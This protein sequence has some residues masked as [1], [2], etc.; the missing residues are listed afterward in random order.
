M[1]SLPLCPHL[2]VVK[3]YNQL[4]WKH[5]I[6]KREPTQEVQLVML[7]VLCVV[8][9]LA[10]EYTSTGG[11]ERSSVSMVRYQS[12]LARQLLPKR[13]RRGHTFTLRLW[14]CKLNGRG[15]AK[16]GAKDFWN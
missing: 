14:Q 5:D 8:L 9:D 6:D 3:K 16:L 15:L 10:L 11:R 7:R 1:D 4:R 2:R 13:L 12:T